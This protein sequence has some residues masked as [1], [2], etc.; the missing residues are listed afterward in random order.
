MKKNLEVSDKDYH[1]MNVSPNDSEEKNGKSDAVD[2]IPASE[3]K[4][5]SSLAEEEN[6]KK[7]S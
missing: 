6:V 5:R 1:L 7:T 3:M 4:K 2:A